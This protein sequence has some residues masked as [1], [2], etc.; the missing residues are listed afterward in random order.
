[1]M[2]CDVSLG[3]F[4]CDSDKYKDYN[5]KPFKLIARSEWFSRLYLLSVSSIYIY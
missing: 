1:M 5:F 3:V 2:F 4:S